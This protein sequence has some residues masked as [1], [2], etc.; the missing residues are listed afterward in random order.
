MTASR[1]HSPHSAGHRQ[2]GRAVRGFSLIELMIAIVLG[3]LL[4]AGITTLFSATTNTN[5]VQ[6]ALARLQENGRYAVTRISDDL[7]MLSGQYCENITNQGW[8]STASNG[9][10]FPDLAIVA[11]VAGVSSATDN[12]FPDSGGVVGA[13]P[14]GL[15]AGTIYNVSPAVFMQGYDCAAAGGCTP[16]V[17]DSGSAADKLPAEGTTDGKRVAGADVLTIRYQRGT[18][19]PYTVDKTT[20]PPTLTLVPTKVGTTQVDDTVDFVTGDRALITTCGGGQVFGVTAAANV[21]TPTDLLDATVFSPNP[22]V[23]SFDSR[24]FNFS[25]DFVTVSYY[26]EYQDD[27]NPDAADDRVIPVLMRKENGGDPAEIVRGVERLDF[28]YGVQYK[29]GSFHYLDAADVDTDSTSTNC[30]TPPPEF[31]SSYETGCLWRSVKTVEAHLLLDNVDDL[32]VLSAQDMKYRY[33]VDSTD[34]QAPGDD[35]HLMRRE[36]VAA[37]ATRNGNQ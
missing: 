34:M 9:P 27:P 17:P 36:F 5:R 2:A 12:A 25:R 4:T 13:K 21:L 1:L 14:A 18:G 22:N 11:N 15:A 10:V 37:V 20:A 30:T 24:V 32:Y 3:L 16:D 26:L 8:T 29:D 19:W 31:G 28:V 35:S 33:S 7:R 23:G 6:E